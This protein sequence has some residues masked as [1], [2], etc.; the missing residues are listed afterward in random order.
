M[1]PK[2]D[3][4]VMLGSVHRGGRKDGFCGGIGSWWSGRSSSIVLR[5]GQ[6]ERVLSVD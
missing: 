5:I 2:T 4:E 6:R 3:P 1:S